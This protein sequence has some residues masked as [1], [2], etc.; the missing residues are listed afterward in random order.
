MEKLNV[1]SRSRLAASVCLISPAII[2][3]PS[4]NK[5]SVTVSEISGYCQIWGVLVLH[6]EGTCPIGGEA[7][8]GHRVS[9]TGIMCGMDTGIFVVPT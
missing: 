4:F 2:H 5:S 1:Q 6:A 7:S 9:Y 8:D 3:T